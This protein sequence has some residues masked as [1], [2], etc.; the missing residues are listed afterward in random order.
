MLNQMHTY[1]LWNGVDSFVHVW[2]KCRTDW[3]TCDLHS[4][5]C[6]SLCPVPMVTVPMPCKS[7]FPFQSHAVNMNLSAIM[8]NCFETSEGA[9]QK[10]CNTRLSSEVM[11]WTKWT[12]QSGRRLGILI[13]DQKHKEHSCILA[14]M[15][16]QGKCYSLS[17]FY[18]SMYFRQSN[19]LFYLS[20]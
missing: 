12:L 6:P 4:S 10:D 2:Y 18:V 3:H 11:K 8:V 1:C 20:Y 15:Y 13:V 16:R 9:R 17:H 5:I 19:Y 7:S 14:A